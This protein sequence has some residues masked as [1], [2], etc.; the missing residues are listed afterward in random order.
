MLAT[1]L[2]RFCSYA[3]T[4]GARL[5]C[6]RT[7]STSTSVILTDPTRT[8]A[9]NTDLVEVA[10]PVW[11]HWASVD[12]TLFS[13]ASAPLS[14]VATTATPPPITTSIPSTS[15]PRSSTP[16]AT[17]V[18]PAKSDQKSSSTLGTGDEAGIGVGVGLFVV[19]AI[20]LAI[21]L[22]LH[23]FRK[24]R[25]GQAAKHYDD[26][27]QDRAQWDVNAW[28]KIS[29]PKEYRSELYGTDNVRNISEMDNSRKKPE[30]FELPGS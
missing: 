13:P 2:T 22:F 10:W 12:L 15:L 21:W 25:K 1:N 5:G 27:H 7:L 9:V 23:R 4:Y 6:Q 20:A 30:T 8:V 3:P 14:S 19:A 11:V 29:A 28:S 18:Q 24:R 17:S 26:Q 16:R